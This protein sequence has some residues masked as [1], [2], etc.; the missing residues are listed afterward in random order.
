MATA[1]FATA[2]ETEEAEEHQFE[3]A[4]GDESQESQEWPDW[5]DQQSKAVTQGKGESSKS[6]GKTGDQPS[7]AEGEATAPPKE[8]PPAPADPKP[9]TSKDPSIKPTADPTQDPIQDQ[10][11]DPTQ[12]PTQLQPR[13]QRRIHLLI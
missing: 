12:D 6:V 10:I 5:D 2:K 7:Q 4:G 9:G 8:N 11:K 13:T 1:R 3:D